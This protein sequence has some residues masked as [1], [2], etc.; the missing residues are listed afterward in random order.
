MITKEYPISVPVSFLEKTVFLPKTVSFFDIET[1][2]LSWCCSP[3]FCAVFILPKA[4]CKN[5]GS[6]SAPEK[7]K[8]SWK[9]FLPFWKTEV[10]LIHFNGNTFDIPLSDAQIYLLPDGAE[11]GMAQ[12]LL[13]FIRSFYLLKTSGL[14]TYAP[15]RS[16]N[17]ILDAEQKIFFPEEN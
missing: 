10:T 17:A 9:F 6:A 8:T 4:G 5:S 11:P 3:Y 2:G 7:K 1:T 13:I 15:K 16:A 12:P 14:E